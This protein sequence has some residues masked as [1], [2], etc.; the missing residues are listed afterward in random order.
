MS[1]TFMI[2]VADFPDLCPS[3]TL[4][5]HCNGLNSIRK[6]QTGLLRTCHGLCCKHLDMLGWFVLATFVICV[7]NFPHREVLVKVG[8]MEFG[9]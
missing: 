3:L 5:V 4:P 8:I 2:C 6:T 7:H 1:P 9:L